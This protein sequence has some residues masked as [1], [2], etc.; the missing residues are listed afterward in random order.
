[1]RAPDVYAAATYL[2]ALG[3]I[4]GERMPTWDSRRGGRAQQQ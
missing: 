3:P 1:M 2:K 4:D